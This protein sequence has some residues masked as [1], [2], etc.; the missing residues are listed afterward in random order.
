[1]AALVEEFALAI[2]QVSEWSRRLN[3]AYAGWATGSSWPLAAGEDPPEMLEAPPFAVR[4]FR[5]QRSPRP[6]VAG[7]VPRWPAGL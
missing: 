2:R 6:P 5:D 3:S 7:S 4:L 1:M